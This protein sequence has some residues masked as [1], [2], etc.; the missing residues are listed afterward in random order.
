MPDALAGTV[1]IERTERELDRLGREITEWVDAR[2]RKDA[3]GRHETSLVHLKQALCGAIRG[4]RAALARVR[5][6]DPAAAVYAACRGHEYRL[7]LVHR[8]WS[9]YRGKFEQRDRDDIEPVLA[10]ADEI[11]WSCYA[12]AARNAA[13]ISGRA[14]RGPA[15]LP[16]VEP[17]Y[18]PEAIPR[19]EPPPDLQVGPGHGVVHMFL[20]KLAIPVVSIP[21][22]CMDEPWWLVHL[23][24]EVGHHLQHDLLPDSALVGAFGDLLFETAVSRQEP[25]L[26]ASAAERWRDWGQEIFADACAVHAIGGWAARAV[27]ELEWFG[28]ASMLA[29]RGR[30]P[31]AVVRLDLLARLAGGL[32][33]AAPLG[34]VDP[35][36]IT[37]GPPV[38]DGTGADLRAAAAEDWRAL[39]AIVEAISTWPMCGLG[40]FKGLFGWDGAQSTDAA[41]ELA[42]YVDDWTGML[43]SSEYLRPD[44]SLPA[45]RWV[46]G[47][48]VAAW[49]RVSAVEDPALR[50]DARS[51][52][53]KRVLTVVA[54]SR[55][56]GFRAPGEPVVPDPE[57]LAAELTDLLLAASPEERP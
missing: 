56:E 18:A 44:R 7:M 30:Y 26:D 12:D 14:I 6:S 13:A 43:L 2:R 22:A 48:A 36:A 39:P 27:V 53:A 55:E 21:P 15:P 42:R 45:A 47:A 34:G 20:R 33:M 41:R 37:T 11:V 1:R 51:R 5:P 40:G 4:L 49:T 28:D 38:L 57:A 16:Y 24:H 50:E 25:R 3:F 10:A 9:W 54:A 8:V 46:A 31:P 52:A 17:H 19:D 35:A 29:R 32:G 23:G